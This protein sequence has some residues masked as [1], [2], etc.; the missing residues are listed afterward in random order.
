M[1]AVAAKTT[2]GTFSADSFDNPQLDPITAVLPTQVIAQAV[3]QNFVAA[4]AWFR[5]QRRSAMADRYRR[6]SFNPLLEKPVVAGVARSCWFRRFGWYSGRSA[7]SASTIR[8]QSGGEMS[9]LTMSAIC[10]SSTSAELKSLPATE[11][12]PEVVYDHGG[13]R[14]VDWIVV[15]ATVVIL[16]EVKSVRPTEPIRMGTTEAGTEL[17]RML[18]KAYKQIN[19]TDELIATQHPDFAHLPS[20]LPRV[21]LIVTMERFDIANAK[22]IQDL[23]EVEPNI[24]T[25]IAASEDVERLAMVKDLDIGTFLQDFLTDPA[26]AG[27]RISNDLAKRISDQMP[28]WTKGGSRT[29]GA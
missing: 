24:P 22:P 17:R 1:Q 7:P 20:H 23:L 29:S 12:H 2:G 28:F 13:K 21:G 27:S 11:V 14:S 25:N 16:V 8:G 3:E 9:S 18:A 26:K 15:C 5:A 19:N 4:S 10:S 6:F